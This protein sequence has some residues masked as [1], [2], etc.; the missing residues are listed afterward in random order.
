LSKR[1]IKYL[2]HVKEMQT[3]SVQRATLT[4]L[5]GLSE[6]LSNELTYELYSALLVAHPFVRY[7]HEE[8]QVMMHRL[9]QSF[10]KMQSFAEHE[11][12]FSPTE[13][14]KKVYVIRN[15]ELQYT[16]LGSKTFIDPPPR[17]EEWVAEPIMW[18][19]WRHRGTFVAFTP[20]DLI[21]LDPEQLAAV[22]TQHPRP[23]C[24]AKCYATQFID[25]LNIDL[26]DLSDFI[27]DSDFVTVAVG[28]AKDA[29]REVFSNLANGRASRAAHR[30][31]T[32]RES[33]CPAESMGGIMLDDM[34][35][36]GSPTDEDNETTD[37]A[38]GERENN[39]AENENVWDSVNDSLDL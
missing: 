27:R 2:G 10:I 21:L 16:Q 30:G 6:A 39:E 33:N 20:C 36:E 25:Y 24:F 38:G 4:I 37:A 23:W 13:L 18:T 7:L 3:T 11:V 17:A 35:A 12:L 19:Q 8:M 34:A 31:T 22:M 29:E 15:G 26:N 14:G 5:A 1:V 32:G 28:R 9:C